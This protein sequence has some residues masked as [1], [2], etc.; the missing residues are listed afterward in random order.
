MKCLKSFHFSNWSRNVRNLF[1]HVYFDMLGIFCTINCYF[2][3][4]I[5]I[6]CIFLYMGTYFK[7][8]FWHFSPFQIEFILSPKSNIF[9]EVWTISVRIMCLRFWGI[10]S[11]KWS[12]YVAETS[13]GRVWKTY[14]TQID[15]NHFGSSGAA[16]P[17]PKTQPTCG[18]ITPQTLYSLAFLRF[19]YKNNLDGRLQI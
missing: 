10:F 7:Y 9:A 2:E 11:P 19:F 15:L 5:R 18:C 13:L 16:K 8:I 12:P 6:M 3:Y 14:E 1:F 4:R 17:P